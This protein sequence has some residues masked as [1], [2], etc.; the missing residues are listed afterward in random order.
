MKTPAITEQKV[1]T[2]PTARSI[3]GGD[4]NEGTGDGEHAVHRRRLQDADHVVG[5][6]EGG[7]GE[8]E[9][10]HETDQAGEGEQ[11]CRADELNNTWR[12]LRFLVTAEVV[13]ED[14]A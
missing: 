9:E 13:V 8:A 5:L 2:V 7:R 14:M 12:G 1:M 3:P 11:F 10:D 6:H 4:D